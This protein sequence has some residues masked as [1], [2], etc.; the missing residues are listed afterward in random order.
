MLISNP[1]RYL[2][3]LVLNPYVYIAS[4]IMMFVFLVLI[5]WITEG[6]TLGK[7]IVGIR[8]MQSNKKRPKFFN[9][10]FRFMTFY[11]IAFTLYWAA[12]ISTGRLP[13]SRFQ[14]TL[15]LYAPMVTLFTLL[16]IFG[17][18]VYA[19]VN[20]VPFLYE[21]MSKINNIT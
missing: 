10:L 17:D 4:L 9:L 16:F 12:L 8:L 6:Y 5:P 13:L 20:E 15:R 14:D 21:R 18:F 19:F 3:E 2:K 7:K 1:L 11:L